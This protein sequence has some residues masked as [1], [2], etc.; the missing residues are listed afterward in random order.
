[1]APIKVL[2]ISPSY[3]DLFGIDHPTSSVLPHLGLGYLASIAMDLGHEVKIYDQEIDSIPLK[4][5]L[6]SFKPNLVGITGATC[7]TNSILCIASV[8]KTEFP[9]ATVIVGGPH[10]SGV[11]S[12]LFKQSKD[13]DAL[14]I[15]EGETAFAE[16]LDK[17]L[18]LSL[19]NHPSIILR[20]SEKKNSEGKCNF[21][22]VDE[23][24]LPSHHL[25]R[26]DLYKP[27]IH[28][29]V[30]FPFAHIV[31][32]RGCPYNC[33][34][35]QNGFQPG[36]EARFRSISSLEKE[37]ELLSETLKIKSLVIWDDIFTLNKDRTKVISKLLKKFN[38]S[39]TCNSRIDCIDKS[40]LDSMY[41]GGCKVIFYGIESCSDSILGNLD[42]NYNIEKAREVIKLTQESGIWIVASMMIGVPWDT[43][44][45]IHNNIETMINLQPEFAFFSPFMPHPGTKIYRDLVKTSQIPPYEKWPLGPS[46]QLFKYPSANPILNRKQIDIWVEAAYRRFYERPKYWEW[47]EGKSVSSSQHRMLRRC[48]KTWKAKYYK[49]S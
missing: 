18:D 37:I 12:I 20:S 25:F 41:E 43:T 13:I 32:M 31:T 47:L 36:G 39:W 46:N 21:P 5:I 29:D 34:Y 6:R 38:L 17:E 49:N 48:E 14:V 1:M 7:S 44:E 42:R 16:I 27:S 9:G 15:G 10:A 4:K 26:Y 33:P 23:L 28:R 2:L 8:S 22:S 30:D 3:R 35:C 45:T 11:Q 40:T 24:P 19:C